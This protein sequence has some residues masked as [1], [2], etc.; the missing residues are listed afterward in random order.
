MI[1]VPVAS[2][3]TFSLTNFKTL[4]MILNPVTGYKL[5]NCDILMRLGTEKY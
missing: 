4:L 5:I 3:G 2:T 1:L